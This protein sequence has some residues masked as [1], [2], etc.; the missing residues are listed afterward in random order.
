MEQQQQQQLQQP[1]VYSSAKT[2]QPIPGT[3]V[4]LASLSSFAYAPFYINGCMFATAEHAFQSCK[5]EDP[6]YQRLFDMT[7]ETYIGDDPKVA[8]KTGGKTFFKKHGYAL[9]PD[10]DQ[11][12]LATMTAIL[13]ERDLQSDSSRLALSKT[14]GRALVHAGF[15]IDRFWGRQKSGGANHH[16]RIL[17]AIRR[18]HSI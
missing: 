14:D 12:R 6:S 7:S 16:G 8:K 15:R 18:M 2:R 5:C 17:M 11:V 13:D 3:T 4:P 9:R 1:L 10:W